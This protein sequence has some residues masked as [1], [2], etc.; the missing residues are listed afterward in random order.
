MQISILQ[1]SP[2]GTV[3]YTETQTPTTNSNGLVSIE[4]GCEADFD[5]IN[6]AEGPYFIEVKTDIEGGNNYT[7]TGT[8][9]L[10]SVPYALYAKE[11]ATV[12]EIDPIFTTWDKST[13]ISITESQ[14]ADLGNYIETETDPVFT[15]WD[16]STGIS[17]TE[18]QIVGITLKLKL[19]P[20]LL[21]INQRAYL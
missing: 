17:I 16:K 7:I 14:I 3:V 10:L 1:G 6:W 20:F 19:T 18:S 2:T 15:T 8:S 13:G 4:I 5:A 9:Q 21:G 11:A 12:A